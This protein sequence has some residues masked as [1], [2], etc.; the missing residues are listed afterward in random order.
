MS[1][2]NKISFERAD[3]IA[4]IITGAI[5]EAAHMSITLAAAAKPSAALDTIE[6]LI[7]SL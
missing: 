1:K 3:S 5:L 7:L 2:E 6:S 4:G